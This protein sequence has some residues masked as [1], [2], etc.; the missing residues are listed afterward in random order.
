MLISSKFTEE[1]V[2]G[3]E[4]GNGAISIYYELSALMKSIKLPKAKQATRYEEK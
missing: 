4:D 3:F 1:F 2:A